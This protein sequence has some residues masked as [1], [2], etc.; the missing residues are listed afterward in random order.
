MKT[1]YATDRTDADT[2]T[3]VIIDSL[4]QFSVSLNHCRG[5]GQ[6]YDGI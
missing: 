6:C 2:I 3:K 5:Q 1:V 4:T